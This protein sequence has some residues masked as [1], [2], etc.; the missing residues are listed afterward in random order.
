[1]LLAA[2]VAIG[3]TVVAV[4]G[5]VG[6]G[7][8]EVTASR[9][10]RIFT[11]LLQVSTAAALGLTWALAG[12]RLGERMPMAGGDGRGDED[13][14]DGDQTADEPPAGEDGDGLQELSELPPPPPP[15]RPFRTPAPEPAP[16]PAPALETAPARVVSQAELARRVYQ[17][18]LAYSPARDRAKQLL[19]EI[20]RAER[21]GRDDDLAGL[22]AQLEAM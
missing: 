18:R 3:S 17:D 21:E 13:T 6:L 10:E 2:A 19:D 9:D 16:V 4:T 14:G 12:S 15:P 7:P 20:A 8:L 11:W 5:S 22:M 1:M